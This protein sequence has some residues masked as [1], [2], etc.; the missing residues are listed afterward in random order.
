MTLEEAAPPVPPTQ[1]SVRRVE[2]PGAGPYV[3]EGLA[4]CPSPSAKLRV[5]AVKRNSITDVDDWFAEHGFVHPPTEGLASGEFRGVPL[6]T[7][8]GD[9]SAGLYESHQ[10]GPSYIVGY[11][12]GPEPTWAL[13]VTALRMTGHDRVMDT[14]HAVLE[15][16]VLYLGQTHLGYAAETGG[17]NAYITAVSVASAE[18]LWRSRPLVANTRNFVVAGDVIVTGYGF[19]S[20]PDFLYALS[21]STGKVLATQ[22]LKKG[23]MYIVHSGDTLEVR[24]YDRD[25]TIELITARAA[26][27]GL[28]DCLRG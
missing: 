5:Q 11:D 23:P 10:A 24:T 14:L 17:H 8:V 20:E 19:T 22:K 3:A 27:S 21:A 12:D 2:L 6:R 26:D 16:G 1:V 15:D 7:F 18:V 25:Y 9:G 28:T 13:D 4:A